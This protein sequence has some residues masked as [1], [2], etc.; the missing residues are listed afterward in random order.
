MRTIERYFYAPSSP[1]RVLAIS[2]LPFSVIYCTIASLKRALA[3]HYDFEI[4]IISIGNIVLGGSGKTP[5]TIEIAREYSDVCEILR[6]Y[7]RKSRGM[8]VVSTNGKIISDVK[9]AGDEAIMIANTLKNASVI[10]SENRYKA[11][12]QAKESGAK[13]IFLDDGF[14]FN[15]R[16]LNIL[17]KPKLE[18]YFALCLPSGGYREHKSA[19]NSADIVA[20]EGIDYKR[21]VVLLNATKRM[22]LL[23][24]IAN[25][26]RLDEY[27]PDVVG[28]IILKDHSF[29]D[30]DRILAKYKSL[31]ATSLLVTQKDA[32]K[33]GN[34][35]P[36]LSFLHLELEISEGIKTAINNYIN[37]F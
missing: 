4:P 24:A 37:S 35:G 23:T 21:K 7:G 17:L 14:R 8:V 5:F 29:F 13:I 30:K 19:Y 6:G 25:P 27:L 2:L 1:Q 34:L 26:S 15:Y 11:I 9:A 36:P 20:T 28:K 33:L 3:R 22:L 31:E 10:V 12:L 18:P 16:K 32:V